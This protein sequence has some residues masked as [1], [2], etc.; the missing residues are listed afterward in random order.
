M[1][2]DPETQFGPGVRVH[3]YEILQ[4]LGKGGMGEV[5]LAK[6]AKLGRKVALKF[7]PKEI[8]DDQLTRERFIHEAK[9]A[10]ALDH[11][12]ICKV[13]ETGEYEGK[14]YIAM[15]YVE[16]DTLKVILERGALPLREALQAT[17]EI[18]E[19]IEHAH[20]Q[21]IVHRDLK[22]AN[23]MCTPQNHV[24]VMD[25]G[26]AKRIVPKG[27]DDLAKTL[28]HASFT[29]QGA[30]AGTISY[31]S[32]EQAKGEKVDGRSDIFALGII[33][34]EMTTGRHP[35]ARSSAMD[36]LT[37]ILRD[38]PPPP[39]IRPKVMNPLLGP[40]LR[41]ALAKDPD[42][43]YQNAGAL[44][45]DIRKLQGGFGSDIR[46]LLRRW[47]V[48]VPAILVVIALFVG[49]FMLSRRPQGARSAEEM[50]PT[51]VL[52]EN[53]NNQ[54]GDS[55]FDGI[56]EKALDI[57]LAGAPFISIYNRQEALRLAAQLDPNAGETLDERLAQLVGRRAGINVIVGGEIAKEDKGYAIKVWAL[58]TVKSEK[59][60]EESLSVGNQN[61]IL[62]TVDQ[63]SAKLKT[64]L[65]DVPADSRQ[66][67]VK[68]TFTT[69]SLEAMKAYAL[70]Q[71]LDDQGKPEEALKEYLR[72]IDHD[73][74]FGRAYS[75]AALIYYNSGRFEEAE[76]YFT[77]AMKRIDQMTDREKYRDRGMYAL[78]KRDF[79]KAIDEYSAL[80][81]QYPGD[82]VIH[83]ML[84][85]AY[86]YARDM[87]NAL[88]EGLLDV[89]YNPQGVWAHYN[90]SWYA[91]A[92]GD[93]QT[94]EEEARKA[95][96]LESSFKKAHITLALT[97]AAEGKLEEAAETFRK[98]Q[99]LDSYGATLATAGL[100]DLAV[101][102]GRLTEASK[103]LNEGIAFDLENG[104][105]Y[106][107]AMKCI[108]LA[109]TNLLQDKKERAVETADRALEISGEAEIQFSAALVFLNAGQ[110]DKAR[111]LQAELNKKPQPEP[112]V[113]AK[114]IGGE[115]SQAR[116]DIGN[117]VSL[118]H[119][120]K[121]LIDTW[122]GHF[123]LGR[124][125][126]Q[127][128]DYTAAYS[129]FEI[130]IKRAG[131]AASVFLND[132][133]TYAYVPPVYYY[134]GRA[135]EGLGSEAAADSYDRF[136]KIKEK[137]DGTDPMVRD[138]RRRLA[139][140]R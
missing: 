82:Y 45:R 106:D 60:Y 128:E 76:A 75:G 46:H 138:A 73:P 43:R 25:F 126:L 24:K 22:P 15:E 17:Q 54:T 10:A 78:M 99:A 29:A 97:Q 27:A 11:P 135:Q 2:S 72:A 41:K 79:K 90:L 57:S 88:K 51:S 39:Q 92:T 58:D 37:S 125:Y 47:Q 69:T 94:A 38:V 3:N 123:F 101:Y 133:P 13:Y 140:L 107:A 28:T 127:A 84:A 67:L 93:L 134:F 108:M 119:D 23:I 49:V 63:F 85:V 81:E 104:Q 112:R 117:A 61:D 122:I 21:G 124:A 44:I 65:G 131:E 132:L 111:T 32:P 103:I 48:V 129:E 9:A 121:N 33:I 42:L 34:Y 64:K 86:F 102:A 16:G 26:L 6:D 14:A 53:F 50:K 8:E 4:L 118:F 105:A 137:D 68:E 136:L 55:I 18:A 130:C 110:E 12:F 1:P 40:I 139:G 115:L 80:L 98:L 74:N 59:I 95:L 77:E 91:L 7:L 87:P 52:V 70:A 20:S 5:Y 114:L 62:K 116:G 56:L 100:A 66:A 96:E 30:I 89:K 83:A 113:Y 109:Q 35:F 31:M 120:A 36:T 71:E 19:A